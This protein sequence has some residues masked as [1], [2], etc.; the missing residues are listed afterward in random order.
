M[1]SLVNLS[2]VYFDPND[3]SQSACICYIC[4]EY[5]YHPPY[6]INPLPLFSPRPCTDVIT[7]S[8]TYCNREI[9]KI[10][11]CKKWCDI[12]LDKNIPYLLKL[13]KR[14][15]TSEKTIYSLMSTFRTT[16]IVLENN[17]ITLSKEKCSNFNIS[18][19]SLQYINSATTIQEFYI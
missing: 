4:N 15:E 12:I 14:H 13:R 18:T 19:L 17:C 16:S 8:E 10:N 9:R 3:V 5:C 2:T 7:L 1:W 11:F 6:V